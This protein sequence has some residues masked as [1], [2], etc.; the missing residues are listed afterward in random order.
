M[1]EHRVKNDF[2]FG[3]SL[4]FS[5]I[6]LMI[7]LAIV[8]ILTALILPNYRQYIVRT[9]AVAAQ[10]YLLELVSLQHQTMFEN[11]EYSETLEALGAPPLESVKNH[12]DIA[13]TNVSNTTTPPTYS[14]QATPK[15]DSVQ[16]D[17]STLS[18]NHLSQKTGDWYE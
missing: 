5:L 2:S 3:F 1:S 12:Y 18:I 15:S 17:T 11:H 9:N 10:Q 7:S 6:E 16:A 14:I 8:G 4:G 13:I